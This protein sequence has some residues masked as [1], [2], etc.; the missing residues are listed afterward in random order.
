LRE[1]IRVTRPGGVVS[2][3]ACFCHTDGLPHYHGR[4]PFP[5]NRRVD[6][7]AQKLWRVFRRNIRPRLLGV[8][9]SRV[10]QDLLWEF[11]ATGLEELQIN[12]HIVLVSPGDSRI[13]L[14]DGAAYALARHEI[15]WKTF[16]ERRE[17]HGDELDKAGFSHAEYEELMSLI[18]VRDEYLR[19]DPSRVREVMEVFTDELLMVRGNKPLDTA[20]DPPAKLMTS[21]RS[22]K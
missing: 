9:L 3:V 11:R 5:G 2:A 12:G 10:S 6:H 1:Q 7:L 14:E 19:A 16:A 21:D 20:A 4:Y 22:W 18:Q 15:I 17:K 13:P 8:D